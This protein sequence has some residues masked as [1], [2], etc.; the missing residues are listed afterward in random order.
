MT[1]L[2]H[3]HAL[4]P[5]IDWAL[6]A[7]LG[8]ILC[9]VAVILIV[10]PRYHASVT[11]TRRITPDLQARDEQVFRSVKTLTT[12]ADQRAPRAGYQEGHRR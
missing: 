7:D 1:A 3:I 5:P 2:P 10:W 9:M 4:L 8:V 12:L 6:I 11:A